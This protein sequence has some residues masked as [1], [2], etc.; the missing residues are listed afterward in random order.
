[1]CY[2]YRLSPNMEY[3]LT[4]DVY[5]NLTESETSVEIMVVCRM[6]ACALAQG[7]K[8]PLNGLLARQHQCGSISIVITDAGRCPVVIETITC[9]TDINRHVVED[10]LA[11]CK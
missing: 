3:F 7:N 5:N 11:T 2:P 4:S 6:M 8:A 10:T 1:M 9:H